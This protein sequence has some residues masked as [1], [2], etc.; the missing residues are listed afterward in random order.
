MKRKRKD[1]DPELTKEMKQ[2][3]TQL[4][5]ISCVYKPQPTQTVRDKYKARCGTAPVVASFEPCIT[6]SARN[7][8]N[9][10]DSQEEES[11]QPREKKV[12]EA[13]DIVGV[14]AGT[15]NSVPSEDDF[16]L[17]RLS[18]DVFSLTPSQ[19]TQLHGM[20]MEHVETDRKGNECFSIKF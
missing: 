5:E 4:T 15:E 7:I 11:D 17:F 14:L 19:R 12:L 18:R 2:Q 10:I 16:W 1:K 9:L 6:E 20:Y 3:R 8:R 13:G